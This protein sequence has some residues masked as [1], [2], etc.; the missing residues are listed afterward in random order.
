MP[1]DQEMRDV[2]RWAGINLPGFH[3]CSHACMVYKMNDLCMQDRKVMLTVPVLM[4]SL[5][6]VTRQVL[7]TLLGP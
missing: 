3:I 1:R 7:R 5:L 2:F 6:E 4:V